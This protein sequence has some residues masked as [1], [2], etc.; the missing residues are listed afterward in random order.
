VGIT[1]LGVDAFLVRHGD[2]VV[3]TAGMLSAPSPLRLLDLR[4]DTARVDRILRAALPDPS[5]VKAVLV[6]HSHYDH[7]MDLPYLMR[8]HFT[9]PS[10]KVW[11]NRALAMVFAADTQLARRIRVI[12]DVAG[13]SLSRGEWRPV[14]YGGFR[15]M[16]L[17]SDHAPHL[18]RRIHVLPRTIDRPRTTP[19]RTLR[20]YAEGQTLAYL[21]DFLDERGRVI[22]RVH[23]QDAAA[24]PRLGWP[25]PFPPADAAPVDVAI[26]CGAAF[27]EVRG[28]P[29]RILGEMKPRMAVV[30]HWEDFILRPRADPAVDV[31]LTDYRALNWRLDRVMGGAEKRWTPRIGETRWFCVCP[32][33][34]SRTADPPGG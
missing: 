15:F 28:Y 27:A 2:D 19:P 4:T 20:D 16:A 30:G 10:V 26:L 21:L 14:P 3:L 6:G 33:P 11:G 13:D 1:Y 22:F 31:P 25:P 29:E 12:E 9:D 17:R 8:R 7:A 5:I 24:T 18:L 34:S 23:Y 32:A